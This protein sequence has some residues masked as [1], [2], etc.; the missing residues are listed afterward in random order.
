MQILGY[1]IS[2]TPAYPRSKINIGKLKI[3]GA[4]QCQGNAAQFLVKF[5]SGMMR[6]SGA[7]CVK[8]R[9]VVTS[10]ASGRLDSLVGRDCPSLP[11]SP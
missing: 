4:C 10:G 8:S 1:F 11:P 3:S 2:C 7:C 6:L 9:R 5:H